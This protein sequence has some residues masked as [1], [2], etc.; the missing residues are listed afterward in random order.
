[1]S[2]EITQDERNTNHKSILSALG[3]NNHLD[4]FNEI[5]DATSEL[6]GDTEGSNGSLAHLETLRSHLTGY[7]KDHTPQTNTTYADIN[8]A[9]RALQGALA[10]AQSH[11]KTESRT[12][13][14]HKQTSESLFDLLERIRS[15]PGDKPSDYGEK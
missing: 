15:Q 6:L 4:L 7:D 1:M 9:C 11:I 14:G 3:I 12:S 2:S 8:R 5:K 10:R 13:I